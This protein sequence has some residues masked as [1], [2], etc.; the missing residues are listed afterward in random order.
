MVGE[1][2]GEQH[3]ERVK[4]QRAEKLVSSRRRKGARVAGVSQS[5]V[6]GEGVGDED[7]EVVLYLP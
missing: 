2:Y 4:A 5:L 3:L 7:G 6:G 1:H